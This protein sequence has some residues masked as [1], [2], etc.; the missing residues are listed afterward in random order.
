[1]LAAHYSNK[2]KAF[3]KT[4]VCVDDELSDMTSV[5]VPRIAKRADSGFDD[6]G[7]KAQAGSPVAPVDKPNDEPHSLDFF[8]TVNAFAGNGILCSVLKPNQAGNSLVEQIVTLAN[9]A[10]VTILDWE[11]EGRSEKRGSEICRTTIKRILERDREDGGRLRLVV[12]FTATDGAQAIED[13]KGELA[14]LGACHIEKEFA[15]MGNYWR[16]VVFQKPDTIKPTTDKVDYPDLPKR[17]VEEFSKLTDGLLPTAI[18]HGITAIRE[19]THRLLAIFDRDL[20]APFLAHRALIP[21]PNDAGEFFLEVFQDE[22]GALMRNHGIKECV[23]GKWS[24][25][26]VKN[27][28]GIAEVK[29]TSLLKAV[30]EPSDDKVKDFCVPFEQKDGSKKKVAD[31]VLQT[32]C[33]GDI[34]TKANERLAQLVSLYGACIPPSVDEQKMQLGVLVFDETN[35]RYLMCLQPLCDSVR[36]TERTLYPFLILD[37]VVEE[38]KSKDDPTSRDLFVQMSSERGVWLQT[39][40]TPKKLVSYSYDPSREAGSTVWKAKKNQNGKSVFETFVGEEATSLAWIGEVKL[41]KAQ[42][43]SSGIA[44]RFHTLGID[45]FE[46]QRLHQK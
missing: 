45:E 46:W 28:V 14:A 5:H 34:T 39:T 25:E 7:Q 38:K 32:L 15:L 20:D 17:V 33:G 44:S 42:R 29:K 30:T 4:V 12:V 10:D 6:D 21:D 16:I 8:A 40:L 11:L 37:E 1:M 22:I 24:K 13:L 31:K 35:K 36:I 26:W 2:A 43:I 18:L 19:N 23:G 9:S 27:V 3:L 41:G